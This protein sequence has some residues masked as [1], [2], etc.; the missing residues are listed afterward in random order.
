MPQANMLGGDSGPINDTLLVLGI[1][2]CSHEWSIYLELY[3]QMSLF[4]G[5][6]NDAYQLHAYLVGGV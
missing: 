6:I 3:W 2:C 5:Y 4:G 1:T